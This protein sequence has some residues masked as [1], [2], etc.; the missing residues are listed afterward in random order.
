MMNDAQI[1]A[2]ISYQKKKIK[3]WQKDW[4]TA[5]DAGLSG[6]ILTDYDLRIKTTESSLSDFMDVLNNED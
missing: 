4:Q 6:R 3:A 1:Q 5:F 2:H